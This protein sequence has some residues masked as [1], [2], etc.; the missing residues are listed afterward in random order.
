MY[1]YVVIKRTFHVFTNSFILPFSAKYGF[2]YKAF[3]DT[4]T[5]NIIVISLLCSRCRQILGLGLSETEYL[6]NRKSTVL[7]RRVTVRHHGTMVVVCGSR[8]ASV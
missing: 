8:S 6:T 2:I 1:I 5:N 4:S 7:V 3:V